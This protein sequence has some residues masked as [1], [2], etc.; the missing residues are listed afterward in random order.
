MKVEDIILV[1]ESE[2]VEAM[3]LVFE[4]MKIVI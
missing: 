3:R 4:R 1:S 2:M